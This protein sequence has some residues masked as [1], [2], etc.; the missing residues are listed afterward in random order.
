[1]CYNK[2]FTEQKNKANPPAPIFLTKEQKIKIKLEK[3]RDALL[4][5]VKKSREETVKLS[6]GKE[7]HPFL[8]PRSFERAPSEVNIIILYNFVL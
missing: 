4:E 2:Y 7:A 8:L 5:F 3:E 1:M 6:E